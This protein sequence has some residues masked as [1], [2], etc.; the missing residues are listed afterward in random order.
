M[1]HALN[2]NC[3]LSRRLLTML[4]PPRLLHQP[5]L[6]FNQPVKQ[7]EHYNGQ[8]NLNQA[9][10]LEKGDPIIQLL[11]HRLLEARVHQRYGAQDVAH[12]HLHLRVPAIEDEVLV[13]EAELVPE[14]G[15]DDQG[16]GVGEGGTTEEVGDEEEH[17][18]LDEAVEEQLDKLEVHKSWVEVR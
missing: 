2:F 13:D 16:E 1:S 5:H 12:D 18:D 3:H 14:D 15:H 7:P 17:R 10:D 4:H 9:D 11:N 6:S 8:S